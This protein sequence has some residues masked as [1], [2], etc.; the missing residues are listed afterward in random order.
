MAAFRFAHLSDPHLPL[1][2]GRPALGLLASKR[3]LGYLSWRRKRHRI[4]RPDVLAAMLADIQAHA[5]D[6]RVVTG[7]LVNIALPDEFVRARD[8]LETVGAP[9]DVTLI[10]GN[11]DATVTFPWAEGLGLWRDWIAGDGCLPAEGGEGPESLFPAVRVRGPVA[12]VGLSTA[13]PTLPLLAT[14]RLGEAQLAR[15]ESVLADLG[16]RGLYRVVLLHHPPVEAH[17]GQKHGGERKALTDRRAFQAMLGRVG[18]ELVLHGHTHCARL[19]SI[20]GPAASIPALAVPSASAAPSSKGDTA[21]WH[22]YA[23]ERAGDAWRLEVTAREWTP[24]GYATAG[25]Y[26]VEVPAVDAPAAVSTA[27]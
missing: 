3:L 26:T 24:E 6:H 20:K 1:A 17:W 23:V 27:S 21:R 11:H 25:R 22:L 2:A 8:W 14:G 18:A 5:P 12:F 19:T 7:D 10:P 15:A 13:V 4:H 16:R 9:A